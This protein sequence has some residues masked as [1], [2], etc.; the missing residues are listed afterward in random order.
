MLQCD[1][2]IAS[3]GEKMWFIIINGHK[4]H[5]FMINNA[6]TDDQTGFH[7]YIRGRLLIDN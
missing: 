1:A 4:M 7:I 6:S 5:N 3:S 2:K